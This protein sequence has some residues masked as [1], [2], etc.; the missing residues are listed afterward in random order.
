MTA[1]VKLKPGRERSLRERHPWV[2][3]GAVAALDGDPEPG[4]TVEVR[5]RDGAFLARGAWSPASQIAVRVFSFDPAEEVSAAF[6]RGRLE[7]AVRARGTGATEPGTA[8]RLVHAES[9]GLPGLVVDR[10]ADWLVCQATSAGAALWLDTIAETLPAL[11]PSSGIYERS[12][13]EVRRKEGLE[14]RAG[15]LRGETPPDRVEIREG[16][17]RYLVDLRA[18]HK[19]GF[20][21]DQR[22]NRAA[23]GARA[24]GRELLNCFAYTGAFGIAALHGGAARV[25]N[26]ESSVPALALAEEIVALNGFDASRVENVHGNV[27]EVLRSWRDAGR[28]FDVIVLDPPRFAE[29]KSQIQRASRGYKD[30]NLLA[31]KLL[32]PGGTLF[33]FSCS[34]HIDAWLFERIVAAAAED[35][36]RD[37]QVLARLGP[38]DDHPGLLGFPEGTYLKGLLCR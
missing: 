22:D 4:A 37:V 10:Y 30:I 21:L 27:F 26:V 24:A 38:P 16:V 6:V 35:A 14:E 29:S 19:T 15:V 13:V 32:R 33:T 18:G 36:R 9:D 17:S 12:D 3:S 28:T 5:S 25:T 20:Y 23:V 11:V 1:V 7:R 2:F 8:C 31:L 34:S